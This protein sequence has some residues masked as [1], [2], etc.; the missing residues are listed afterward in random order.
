MKGQY[1]LLHNLDYEKYVGD[2]EVEIAKIV[3]STSGSDVM[4]IYYDRN[5]FRNQGYHTCVG[6]FECND[7]TVLPLAYIDDLHRACLFEHRD[8]FLC[9]MLHEMGHFRNGD[10]DDEQS[11]TTD[12]VKDDRMENILNGRVQEAERKADAFAISCVGKNTFMR[13]MDYLINMRK[14][15]GDKSAS[16]AIK[17][18]ELRKKAAQRI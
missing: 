6:S 12:T 17:E 18:F 7:G 11:K 2:E 15:R 13:T 3:D 14:Q 4:Y 1:K 10:L 16:L 8:L 5:L 9:L